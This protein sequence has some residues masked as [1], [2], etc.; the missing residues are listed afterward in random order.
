MRGSRTRCLDAAH[1]WRARAPSRPHHVGR[2]AAQRRRRPGPAVPAA[3]AQ[4]EAL[5]LR[6]AASAPGLLRPLRGAR[7][8]LLRRRP[9]RAGRR[10]RADPVPGVA[11]PPGRPQRH[12]AVAPTTSSRSPPGCRA[13]RW[14]RRRAPPAFAGRHE[15]TPPLGLQP[16]RRGPL[17]RPRHA[18]APQ[19][20]RLPGLPRVGPRRLRDARCVP[21]FATL[22]GSRFG[23]VAAE[24]KIT[25]RSPG[26]LGEQIDT[27][28]SPTT[29][30]VARASGSSSRCASASACSPTATAVNVFYDR[31]E[32]RPAPLLDRLR[33]LRWSPTVPGSARP[34]TDVSQSSRAHFR[35]R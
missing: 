27:F 26:H 12:R 14:T 34:A 24:T 13:R 18:R 21:D 7:D 10:A 28:V 4:R 33:A 25:Y 19:Q 6:G 1:R 17:Q 20:R 2:A 8:R 15:R 29:R 3:D 11:L 35:S 31:K 23:I 22:V 5:A 9:D 32:A 16:L 30:S